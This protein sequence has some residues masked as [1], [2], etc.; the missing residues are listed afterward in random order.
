MRVNP[1]TVGRVGLPPPL[2]RPTGAK[3]PAAA[4]FL[5]GAD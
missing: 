5:V 1:L 3:K 2:W 4:G